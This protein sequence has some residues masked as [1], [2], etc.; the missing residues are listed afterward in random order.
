[1]LPRRIDPINRSDLDTS[2]VHKSFPVSWYQVAWS[3][4][5]PKQA[6][7]AVTVCGMDIV[8]FRGEDN[9]VHALDAYCPHLGAH[10][11]VKG[12]VCGN[13]IRC[14]FH[15]WEFD[16]TGACKKIPSTATISSRIKTK[17]WKVIERYGIVFI[18]FNP[19]GLTL[20]EDG[21]HIPLLEKGEW[22]ACVG[23]RHLIHTRQSDV[24]ENGVDIGHFSSVHGVP[25]NDAKLV[26]RPDGTLVFQHQTITRRLGISFNTYMEIQYINPGLQIIYLESV[27][28]QECI[29]LSS[30]MPIDEN[31]V[32]AHLTVRI[33]KRGFKPWNALLTRTLAYFINS[34]FSED[35][36]IWDHKTYKANPMLSQ[37]EHSIPRFRKWYKN[38]PLGYYE[39][40]KL[41]SSPVFKKS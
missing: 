18:H 32:I 17:S 36:P 7:K 3:E 30:V 25:M 38:F 28:G 41:E 5:V 29:A 9:K 34:T 31:K 26:D 16:G 4:E 35:I 40:Q 11:A 6:I 13:F 15:N 14:A 27:L 1:M 21:V 8:L 24:L 2:A 12:K 23:K 19:Q 20:E 10:L 39:N 37:G 22:G 33:R